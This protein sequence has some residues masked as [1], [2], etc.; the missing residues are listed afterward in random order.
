MTAFHFGSPDRL[1]PS[2]SYGSLGSE[3]IWQ[4][5]L[6]EVTCQPRATAYLQIR[7]PRKPFPPQTMMRFADMTKPVG[8]RL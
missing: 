6:I 4:S 3:D 1:N 7:E 2:I 8:R 5:Y